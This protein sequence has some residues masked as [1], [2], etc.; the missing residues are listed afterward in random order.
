MLPP[1]ITEPRSRVVPFMSSWMVYWLLSVLLGAAEIL[2]EIPPSTRDW[3]LP[4]VTL[5]WPFFSV[6][7]TP[8][9]SLSERTASLRESSRLAGALLELP[10]AW[11]ICWLREAIEAVN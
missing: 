8:I 11:E 1:L 7:V 10:W 9:N 5:N 3:P 6:A 2:L 4:V